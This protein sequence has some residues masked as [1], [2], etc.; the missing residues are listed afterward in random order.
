M[1]YSFDLGSGFGANLAEFLTC[2][3]FSRVV[4]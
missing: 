3:G 4:I 1:V 2:C